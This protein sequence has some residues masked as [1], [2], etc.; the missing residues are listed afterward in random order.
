M[1]RLDDMIISALYLQ[2]PGQLAF[3]KFFNNLEL[4]QMSCL[5]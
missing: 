1:L 3:W 4:E 2:R 5:D